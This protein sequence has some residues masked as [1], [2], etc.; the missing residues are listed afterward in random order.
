MSKA[1]RYGWFGTVDSCESILSAA[2]EFVTMRI[3]PDPKAMTS[4]R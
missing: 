2:E 4:Q 3:I 1:K